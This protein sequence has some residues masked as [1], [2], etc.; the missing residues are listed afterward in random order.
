MISKTDKYIPAL[1]ELSDDNREEATRYLEARIAEWTHWK[2]RA[3]RAWA[4]NDHDRIEANEQ[5]QYEDP[6]AVTVYRLVRTDLST[7]GP[8][9]WLEA[10]VDED[11]YITRIEWHFAPWFAHASVVLEGEEKDAAE[12][13]VTTVAGGLIENV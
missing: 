3:G 4:V 8:G 11:G 9:D 5:E 1:S 2:T 7:G 13:Y 10:L 12:A 6:L